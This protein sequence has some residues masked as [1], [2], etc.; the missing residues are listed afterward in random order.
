MLQLAE[1]FFKL[2]HSVDLLLCQKAGEYLEQIPEGVNIIALPPTSTWKG[3]HLAL[4]ADM[5]GVFHILLPIMLTPHPPHTIRYLEGLVHYLET[6]RPRALLAAKT[7]ANLVA[8][9]A[10]KLSKTQTRVVIS[11]RTSL[12]PIMA[13]KNK[14]RWRFVAPAL[15]RIYPRA[16]AITAVSHGVAQDLSDLSNIPLPS[17]TTI[18]NP[19]PTQLIQEKAKLEPNHPWFAK[20]APPVILG[21]GR[22]VPQKDFPCLLEAFQKIRSARPARLVILGEGRLR[23]ELEDQAQKLGI[24]PDLW[25]PGFV[26][27]PYTYMARASVFVLSS[28]WEGLPNAL[29]EA[30]ACGCPIV[31]TD[32]PSGPTEILNGGELAPLVPVADSLA[33]SN[34]IMRVLKSPQNRQDLLARA[35]DFDSLK[36]ARRYLDLLLC[37]I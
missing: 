15:K 10:K 36:V 11:E 3:R 29:L 21:V 22:L 34:A 20:Q 9:L 12:T 24:T 19:L 27:N 14:W 37:D 31:S 25:M 32:C 13:T 26:E 35:E 2:G 1:A 8:L 30:L 18:Y 5:G 17:I 7:P 33:L 23:K 6:V 4:S 28:A 16:D